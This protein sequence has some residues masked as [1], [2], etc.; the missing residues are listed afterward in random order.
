MLT[1]QDV[2]R[3]PKAM[4]EKLGD[5]QTE[6]EKYRDA[7]AEVQCMLDDGRQEEAVAFLADTLKEF[8]EQEPEMTKPILPPYEG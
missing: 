4:V 1:D 3:N 8:H 6:M 5:M 2:L 7:C